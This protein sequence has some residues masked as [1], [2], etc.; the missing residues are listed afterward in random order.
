MNKWWISIAVFAIGFLAVYQTMPKHEFRYNP[1]VGISTYGI[2]MSKAYTQIPEGVPW[3]KHGYVLNGEAKGIVNWPAMAFKVLAKWFNLTGQKDIYSARLWYAILYGFNA[4]LFFVFML[5]AKVRMN[6]A[7]IS[8][9]CFIFLPSHLDFG[10]LIYADQ[11]F[12]TI[13]LLALIS[14]ASKTA[15]GQLFFYLFILAGF[16]FHWFTLFFLPAPLLYWLVKHYKL[17]VKQ[18]ILLSM[19]TML[20]IWVGQ[21][22]L[23][24]F[25][26]DRPFVQKLQ[27][28]S[29]FGLTDVP[30]SYPTALLKRFVSLGYEAALII[31]LMML[32]G[33]SIVRKRSF[34]NHPRLTHCLLIISIA[35]F[36]YFTS[37][38]NWFGYHRHGLGMFSFLIAGLA[39]LLLSHLHLISE[40]K[41]RYA[42]I[43]TI[44]L[45]IVMFF[46]LSLMTKEAIE[47]KQQDLRIAELINIKRTNNNKKACLFF[48]ESGIGGTD[49]IRFDIS[50]FALR[51]YTN[52]YT[53]NLYEMEAQPTTTADLQYGISKLKINGIIDFDPRLVF[54]ISKNHHQFDKGKVVDS[55][56]INQFNIYHL[57]LTEN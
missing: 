53:F 37:F 24:E 56:K 21:F 40:K 42:S 32:I 27:V 38:V 19:T 36:L 49:T 51:E 8:T 48:D 1:D 50:E 33:T 55:V 34:R 54:M 12:I 44:T 14:F 23:F 2:A 18:I 29:I 5:S 35:L 26:G 57:N 9:L 28:Y 52:A 45:P 6:V 10:A 31:P 22:L 15:I 43:I 4:F 20:I 16:F 13:C 39:A 46:S 3:W 17:E 30:G 7:C 11:W 25:S 41:F 47:V